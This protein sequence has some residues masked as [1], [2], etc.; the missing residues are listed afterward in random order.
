MNKKIASTFVAFIYENVDN[1]P[2]SKVH[3]L[4]GADD[5]EPGEQP[6]GAPDG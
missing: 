6:H 1:H 5:G 2:D 4:H 3:N